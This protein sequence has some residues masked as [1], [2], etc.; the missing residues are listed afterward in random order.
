MK[1]ILAP[2]LLALALAVSGCAV[3][4]THQ[5]DRRPDG[6][7]VSTKA[8]QYGFLA[9]KSSLREFK[10]SQTA[11]TQGLSVGS[12]DSEADVTPLAQVLGQLAIQGMAAYM[13]GGATALRSGPP[14][15]P[16]GFKLVPVDDPSVPK[17][18][19]DPGHTI[20]AMPW[21]YGPAGTNWPVG[22]IPTPGIV[23]LQ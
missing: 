13:S 17:L 3:S 19:I 7:E 20:R 4:S 6:T 16:P 22:I 18:E 10:A 14:A 23:T 9:G 2:Y 12:V 8:K 15:V 5:I 11:K 21:N 1:A